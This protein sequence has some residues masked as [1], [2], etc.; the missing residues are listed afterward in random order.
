MGRK[1]CGKRRTCWL[2]AFSPFPT[3]FTKGFFFRIVKSLDCEVMSLNVTQILNVTQNC[4]K[5]QRMFLRMVGEYG[6]RPLKVRI[7][8]V[9]WRV[10]SL[11]ND[12]ILEWSKIIAYAD[13]K[14]N[15]TQNLNFVLRR[16]ENILGKG[17]NAGYQY[18]LLFP[19]MF[20]KSFFP[21]GC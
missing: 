1:H 16:V 12:K 5:R 18:F 13:D 4:R 9:W 14:I 15:V 7:R 10:Y 3:I 21:K 6:Q 8:I 2:P 20:S 11:P 17:E 19:K